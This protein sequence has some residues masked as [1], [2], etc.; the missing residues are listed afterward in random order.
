MAGRISKPLGSRPKRKK[1]LRSVKFSGRIRFYE[2]VDVL[3]KARLRVMD[4]R[5]AAHNQVF[6]AM[7]LEGG[8][9]VFVVLVHQARSSIP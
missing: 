4:N 2:K 8:Q 9:K 3:R 7:G 6:N 1:L 5:K